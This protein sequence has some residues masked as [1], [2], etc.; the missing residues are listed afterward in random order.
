MYERAEKRSISALHRGEEHEREGLRGFLKRCRARIA[1]E[2]ASL[3][4][5]LRLPTRVG[6]TVTQEEVAEAVGITRVWYARLESDYPISVSTA[7]LGRL[8]D[9]L[10]MDP[11]EREALFQLAVP[12]LRTAPLAGASIAMLAAFGS[13]RVVTRRLWAAT[14][15]AEALTIAREHTMTQLAPDAVLTSARVGEG[16]WEHAETDSRTGERMDHL[17]ALLRDR[18]GPTILDDLHYYGRMPQPGDVL[19]GAEQARFPEYAELPSVL[20]EM[21]WHAFYAVGTIRTRCGLI[22]RLTTHYRT[23]HEFSE[24]ERAQLSALADLTS[25]ALSGSVLSSRTWEAPSSSES[26]SRQPKEPHP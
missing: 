14:T 5:Y 25:L 21:D 7:V 9:A 18:S 23:G 22:A 6:K 20:D 4:P 12:E 2:R 11:T 3:G 1:P 15:E 17:F 24:I 19:T 10:M 8:A 16:R 13:L 26:A